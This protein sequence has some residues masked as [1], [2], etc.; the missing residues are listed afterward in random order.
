VHMPKQVRG[1]EYLVLAIE[2]FF[3]YSKGRELTSNK[4]EAIYRFIMEDIMA[5]YGYFDHIRLG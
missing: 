3:S 4:I 5:R 1:A 2:D